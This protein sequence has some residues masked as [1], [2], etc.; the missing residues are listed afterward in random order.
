MDEDY[1]AGAVKG[2]GD[3][4]QSSHPPVAEDN[5]GAKSNHVLVDGIWTSLLSVKLNWF[6][7]NET[8]P[9]ISTQPLNGMGPSQK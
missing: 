5:L 8:L 9:F 6:A 1:F 2:L 4:F 7:L 3:A